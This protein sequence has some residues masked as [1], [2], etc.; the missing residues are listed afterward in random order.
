MKLLFRLLVLFPAFLYL[1][2]TEETLLR[3]DDDVIITRQDSPLPLRPGNGIAVMA[4][5]VLSPGSDSI[6]FLSGNFSS[7][8][9]PG[10][11][12]IHTVYSPGTYTFSYNRE[13]QIPSSQLSRL[14]QISFT[15]RNV[16]VGEHTLPVPNYQIQFGVFIRNKGVIQTY[17]YARIYSGSTITIYEHN[18]AERYI[19]ASFE[20]RCGEVFPGETLPR[21][22]HLRSGVFK[23]FF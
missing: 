21:Q 10:F 18:Q 23:L 1:S 6:Q 19:K 20:I 16:T 14:E 2:C 8:N 9:D 17:R 12:E 22:Y 4:L 3:D 11:K 7:Y 5:S 13:T 15:L